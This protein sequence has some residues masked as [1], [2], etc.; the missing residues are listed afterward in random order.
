RIITAAQEDE[1]QARTRRGRGPQTRAG[2]GEGQAGEALQGSAAVHHASFSGTSCRARTAGSC[3]TLAQSWPVPAPG[4]CEVPGGPP[5]TG[6]TG[7]W[8]V[9]ERRLARAAPDRRS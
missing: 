8:P 7:H 4:A 2:G 1:E 9:A 3:S 5:A 6:S